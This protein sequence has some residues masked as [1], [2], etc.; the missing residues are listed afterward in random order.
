MKKLFCTLLAAALLLTLA[1]CSKAPEAD[2]ADGAPDWQ[3]QYDLG[4]RYLSEGNYEEAILAFE[5]A[6]EIDPR[7]ADAYLKLAEAYEKTGDEDAA[8]RT[9]E[10]GAEATGDRELAD[11][12]EKKRQALDAPETSDAETSAKSTRDEQIEQLS[13]WF[14]QGVG[15]NCAEYVSYA[16]GFGV[17]VY[18]PGFSPMVDDP[19]NTYVL[20]RSVTV[21]GTNGPECYA[22][23]GRYEDYAARVWQ[24]VLYY[25]VFDADGA[26]VTG[27]LPLPTMDIY[28]A[29]SEVVLYRDES[30]SVWCLEV[31]NMIA[32]GDWIADSADITAFALS[33]A[34]RMIETWQKESGE[35][36]EDFL[37]DVN[38]SGLKRELKAAGLPHIVYGH[39]ENSYA[40]NNLDELL[41]GTSA[42]QAIWLYCCDHFILGDQYGA[43]DEAPTATH[44]RREWLEWELAEQEQW[45]QQHAADAIERDT[46]MERY[47]LEF[48]P[49]LTREEADYCY[50]YD[51]GPCGGYAVM[52]V[53]T[54]RPAATI[55]F[56]YQDEKSREWNYRPDHGEDLT[57]TIYADGC[58][59]YRLGNSSAGAIGYCMISFDTRTGELR[60]LPDEHYSPVQGRTYYAVGKYLL[61]SRYDFENGEHY[62]ELLTPRGAVIGGLVDKPYKIASAVVCRRNII[63]Y[64]F[65]D[66]SVSGGSVE[67]KVWKYDLESGERIR[68][69]A[70]PS[71]FCIYICDRFAE[72]YDYKHGFAVTRTYF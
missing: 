1:A 37:S 25:G 69:G 52:D 72:H 8:L 47:Q 41:C 64:H 46:A 22:L 5:A 66:D 16:D 21:D 18:D 53:S 14:P 9:L 15:A 59:I 32:S 35:D 12:A 49:E 29:Q 2:P 23:Y 39:M 34:P 50:G 20:Y 44:L 6:I 63:Y 61:G 48:R 31:C 62:L 56:T 11:L 54:G 67:S 24:W 58:I 7:N 26:V 65:T 4:V 51:E 33:G 38:L 3:T 10:T 42:R 27:E 19:A 57:H 28:N 17:S 40:L 45:V 70:V 68:L 13:G 55:C 71:P 36:D 60:V 43:D 30:R